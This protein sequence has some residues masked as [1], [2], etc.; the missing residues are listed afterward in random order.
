M[1]NQFKYRV[2]KNLHQ[3]NW[4]ILHKGKV[5]QHADK[6]LLSEVYFYSQPGGRQRV[7]DEDVKNVH[8][9][10]CT[11]E[12]IEFKDVFAKH[13]LSALTYMISYNPKESSLFYFTQ[14]K[15]KLWIEPDTVIGSVIAYENKLWCAGKD[16]YIAL[17]KQAEKKGESTTHLIKEILFQNNE[18]Y[19]SGFKN[20]LKALLEDKEFIQANPQG[21]NCIGDENGFSFDYQTGICG[22]SYD[23]LGAEAVKCIQRFM[24]TFNPSWEHYSNDELYPIGAPN[25]NAY[26]LYHH[27]E[28]YTGEYGELRFKYAE[29]L[30]DCLQK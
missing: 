8:A 30:L 12:P 14:N 18:D 11:N 17:K 13:D 1:Q 29:Y 3:K 25:K 19:F 24:G 9:Y 7:I 22:N 20:Y 2:Y 5:V 16:V 15:Q 6:L 28:K 21:V 4:S 26:D 23:N 10:M 27:Q